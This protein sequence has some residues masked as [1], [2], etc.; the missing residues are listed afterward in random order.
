VARQ[1]LDLV[2]NPDP[3]FPEVD[4]AS[5]DVLFNSVTS[6]T[7]LCSDGDGMP[8]RGAKEKSEA[9]HEG[10]TAASGVPTR[11]MH[12]IE[13]AGP[14]PEDGDRTFL[15]RRLEEVEGRK[16]KTQLGGRQPHQRKLSSKDACRGSSGSSKEGPDVRP[17]SRQSGGEGGTV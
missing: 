5:D 13:F 6:M 14:D 8:W 9:S 10:R 3:S 1:P 15:G 12:T 7:Q 17:P 11:G 16:R 2:I 4:L